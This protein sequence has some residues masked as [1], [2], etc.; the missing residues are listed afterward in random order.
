MRGN[1]GVGCK[2]A[3][4]DVEAIV[5][6]QD[7]VISRGQAVA[8]GLSDDQVDR[9]LASGLWRPVLPR[10]YLSRDCAMTPAGRVRATALWAGKDAVVSG[11]AAAWWHGLLER[12]PA[13]VTVTVPVSRHPRGGDG[14]RV[15]RRQLAACDRALVRGVPVTSLPL[16]VLEAAVELG[17][18]G[19]RFMDRALQRHIRFGALHQAHSRNLGRWGSARSS[20]LLVAAADHAGS[21]A[22]RRLVALLRSA[23]IIGWRLHVP[24]AGYE[25]DLAFPAARVAVEV[26]GWAWHHDVER[27]RTDRAKQNALVLGG[28]TV[29]RFTWHDLAQRS[30]RVLAAVA[31]ALEFRAAA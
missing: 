11:S 27:F 22:E 19:P 12:C 29:L 20:R 7:G 16:T 24:F 23:G 18:A 21:D 31:D 30:D 14:I 5:R 13:T 10:V 17:N 6:R 26:D 4:V 15:R 1:V 2:G 9:R 25:L 28:W 8:A 3:L